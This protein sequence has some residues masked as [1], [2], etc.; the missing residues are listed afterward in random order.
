MPNENNF[1]FLEQNDELLVYRTLTGFGFETW[2]TDIK[3]L[4]LL[5]NINRQFDSKLLHISLANT[6]LVPG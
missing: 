1:S 3:K 2:W 6:N 5:R 4:I